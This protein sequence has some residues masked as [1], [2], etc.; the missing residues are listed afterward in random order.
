M[1]P[2]H[3][4]EDEASERANGLPM[5]PW[6]AS[7]SPIV[8]VQFGARF[9][10]AILDHGG[11]RWAHALSLGAT[12]G[13]EQSPHRRMDTSEPVAATPT[14]Q[15]GT[16]APKIAGHTNNLANDGSRAATW[17]RSRAET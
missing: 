2:A 13:Y 1:A 9:C 17:A 16:T 14:T 10:R 3:H 15:T 5:A 11:L 6:L 8:G 4:L 12:Q 7:L